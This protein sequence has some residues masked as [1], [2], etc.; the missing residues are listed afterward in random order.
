ML[1]KL[2]LNYINILKKSHFKLNLLCTYYTYSKAFK[3]PKTNPDEPKGF[4][5]WWVYFLR[6]NRFSLIKCVVFL[7]NFRA[8][9]IPSDTPASNLLLN[10][11]QDDSQLV[12]SSITPQNC[13]R[14]FIQNIIQYDS[15]IEDFNSQGNLVQCQ[16]SIGQ[17][18]F[19]NM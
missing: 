4:V 9:D 12:L 15:Y 1:T 13:L 17:P 16:L 7:L 8:P 6:F 19:V 5:V 11:P 14:A 18:K 10:L 2:N 3:K